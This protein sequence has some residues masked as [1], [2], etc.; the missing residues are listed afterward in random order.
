MNDDIIEEVR[1]AR[2]SIAA[3][4]DY[5]IRRIHA[6]GRLRDKEMASG[7]LGK[8]RV[9]VNLSKSPNKAV[10]PT[11]ISGVVT[12]SEVEVAPATHGVG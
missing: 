8:P 12:L 6:W 11:P 3:R 2:E 7:C 4:F 1:R 9:F 10:Q 5:D